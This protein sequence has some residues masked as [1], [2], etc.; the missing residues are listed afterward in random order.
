MRPIKL[1]IEI[2]FGHAEWWLEQKGE[3]TDGPEA[4]LEM[5]EEALDSGELTIEEVQ[6]YLTDYN[7]KT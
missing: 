3:L 1:Q 6:Q 7:T 4:L 5:L 2:T